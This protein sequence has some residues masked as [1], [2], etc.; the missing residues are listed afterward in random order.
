VCAF[1]AVGGHFAMSSPVGDGDVRRPAVAPRLRHGSSLAGSAMATRD[2]PALS[3]NRTSCRS[4]LRSCRRRT[5]IPRFVPRTSK[6]ATTAASARRLQLNASAVLVAPSQF[7]GPAILL[8]PQR[9]RGPPGGKALC[10]NPFDARDPPAPLLSAK[11]PPSDFHLLPASPRRPAQLLRLAT[12]FRA[13]HRLMRP[14]TRPS[15]QHQNAPTAQSTIAQPF[16]PEG[17]PECQI[18]LPRQQNSANTNDHEYESHLY[19]T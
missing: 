6:N 12:G 2:R 4:N 13:T 8:G 14:A 9:T 18:S 19:V 1:V 16:P 11:L 5:R 7:V 15:R 3:R 17:C 10:P